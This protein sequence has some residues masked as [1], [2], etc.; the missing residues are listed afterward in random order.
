MLGST[1]V[2]AGLT[3]AF[4]GL[5][6]LVKPIRSLRI[7]TRARASAIAA[8]GVLMAGVVF[9][10][11]VSESRIDRVETRLDQFAPVWQFSEFHTIRIAAPPPRVY[12]AIKHVRADEIFLFRTLT[13][14]RR[15]GRPLPASI[16]NAAGRE[17]LLDLATRTSFVWLAGGAAREMGLGR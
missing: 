13:W 8:F 2:Y 4:V 14:I 17:S 1:I 3:L 10:L 15:G 9:A 6:C 5:I 7:P 12:E 11:P 16:L